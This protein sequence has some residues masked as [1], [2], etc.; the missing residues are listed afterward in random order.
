MTKLINYYTYEKIN[1]H[2][3]NSK[4]MEPKLQDWNYTILSTHFSPA[5]LH[6]ICGSFKVFLESLYFWEIQNSIIIQG[7]FP[8]KSP[9]VQLYTSASNCKGV[10]NIPGNQSVKAVAFLMLQP[11]QM[12]MGY[13][14]V[15]SH[16]SLLRRPWP[17]PTSMPENCQEGETNCWFSFS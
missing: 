2:L 1:Q 4:W 15:L 3:V 14:P 16:H 9:L 10:G 11:G 5:D 8:S 7:T 13:A 17:K 6:D 12:S